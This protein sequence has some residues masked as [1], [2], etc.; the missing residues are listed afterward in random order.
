[1]SLKLFITGTDTDIGKTYIATALLRGFAKLGFSTL[2]IKPIASGC[3]MDNGRLYNAD[4][5]ALQQAS[6][7]KLPYELINPIALQPA[8]AP[9]VAAEWAQIALTSAWLQDLCLPA[10]NYPADIC[11]VEGAGG[12]LAPLN[13]QETLADFAVALQLNV[14]L[15]VGMR[16]GCLNHT[17][18]TYH[19]LQQAKIKVVGWIANCIT[20]NM[21]AQHESIT[22]LQ[23]WLAVPCLGVVPYQT[24]P[25]SAINFQLFL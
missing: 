8:I 2:G 6:S 21:P 3:E 12:W 24:D 9:H 5:L 25:E 13:Q 23:N 19:A 10:L 4:A 11:V 17:L 22:T 1:V 16:L 20:P 15:V 7:I 18:L 14:V